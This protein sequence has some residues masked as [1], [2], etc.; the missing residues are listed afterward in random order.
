MHR[1]IPLSLAVLALTC[2]LALADPAVRV[3]YVDGSPQV[4][5]DGSYSG[6]YYVVYR[7][8]A[9][10]AGYRA[11]TN[12]HVLCLGSCYARDDEA[13][14]GHTYYYRFDLTPPQGSSV[15]FGPYAALIPE[16]P[17][18]ARLSPNPLRGIASVTLSLPG[19]VREASVRSE[20]RILDAQGRTVRLLHDGPLARGSTTLTWD[21]HG[22][23]GQELGAGLYFLRLSSPLGNYTTRFVRIR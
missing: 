11:I 23:A 19:S 6:S 5:L 14:P 16:N 3:T 20:V 8:D 21:G 18:R 17:V 7:A 9:P 4:Q 2:G 12:D 15:S 13:L 10:S 22:D 1:A